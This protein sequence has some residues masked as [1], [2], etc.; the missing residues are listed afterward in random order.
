M[1]FLELIV[2]ELLIFLNDNH[3]PYQQTVSKGINISLQIVNNP[4]GHF[5]WRKKKRCA[6]LP[7]SA[8]TPASTSVRGLSLILFC[9]GGKTPKDVGVIQSSV[10]SPMIFVAEYWGNFWSYFDS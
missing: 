5:C 4:L 8:V 7:I 1:D 2:L 3:P 9:D 6:A 10:T